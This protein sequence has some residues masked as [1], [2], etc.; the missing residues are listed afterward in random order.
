MRNKG[1]TVYTYSFEYPDI[2]EASLFKGLRGLDMESPFHAEDL[3]YVMGLA[4]NKFTEKDEKIRR[5]YSG[6]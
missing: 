3:V 2:G 5:I 1:A 6:K 4:Y